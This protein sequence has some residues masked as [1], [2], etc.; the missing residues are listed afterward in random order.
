MGRVWLV[1]LVEVR[2]V[3]VREREYRY[4]IVEC[5]GMFNIHFRIFLRV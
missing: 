4:E 2:C 5:M 1:W 3:S